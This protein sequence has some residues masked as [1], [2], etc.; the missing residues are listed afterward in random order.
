MATRTMAE[1]NQVLRLGASLRV[2]LRLQRHEWVDHWE[3]AAQDFSRCKTDQWSECCD[4]K[5]ASCREQL[6]VWSRR[7][8]LPSFT[9][10]S[11]NRSKGPAEA[12]G[13]LCCLSWSQTGWEEAW[14]WQQ[15]R[16][17]EAGTLWPGLA[18]GFVID[19]TWGAQTASC[20]VSG[21]VLES[22]KRKLS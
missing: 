21:L 6:V 9:C 14:N 2:A 8:A 5:G 20:V 10:C 3:T 11:Q 16:W 12:R 19:K 22:S 4:A 15:Q 17:M 1:A 13:A 7:V 18:E